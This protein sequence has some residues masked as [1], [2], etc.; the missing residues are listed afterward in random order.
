MLAESKTF[1]YMHCTYKASSSKSEL[2]DH[3]T[4]N[5]S[6][7]F[8]CRRETMKGECKYFL[9]SW[10]LLCLWNHKMFLFLYGQN[11]TFKSTDLFLEPRVTESIEQLCIMFMCCDFRYLCSNPSPPL[12]PMTSFLP[13]KPSFQSHGSCHPFPAPEISL[14]ALSHSPPH[15]PGCP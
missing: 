10:C 5:E 8:R 11:Q 6:D 9:L 7:F 3:L 12:E 14:F 15:K 13:W 4:E 2:L 1:S